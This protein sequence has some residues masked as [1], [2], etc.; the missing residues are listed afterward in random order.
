ME[1]SKFERFISKYNLGGSCESVLYK[2]EGQTLT[3]R[4]IS[5]DKN[6]M[7]EVVGPSMGFE[8]GNY[9]VYDTAKLRAL[10]GVLGE[11]LTVSTKKSGDKFVGLEFS[12]TNS[13]VTFVLAD[14]SVIPAVPDL[15]TLPPF[16]MTIVMDEQ[17][18][19]T[20]VK[21]KGA[22]NDVDT[23]TVMSNG[24]DTTADV[25]IGFSSLNTNRVKLK[26]NV[27]EAVE[28]KPI[29]FSASYLREILVANKDAK[30]GKLE[31]SS[32]GLARTSFEI[33]GVT[34][35]YYLVQKDTKD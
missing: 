8:A 16:H 19:N 13:D 28:M 1:K 34:S 30:G 24:N 2:V 33:D 17:F 31:I 23:F 11:V 29:S 22:L 18:T 10:L 4:A 15:K 6:V 5:D 26:A 3:T 35:T 20:F 9:P 21:A 32:K 27:T 25:V 14:A 7:C 12:D